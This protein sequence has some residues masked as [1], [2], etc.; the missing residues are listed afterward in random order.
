M[1][2]RKLTIFNNIDNIFIIKS[3]ITKRGYSD[4]CKFINLN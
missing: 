3:F 4:Y 1:M 2:A